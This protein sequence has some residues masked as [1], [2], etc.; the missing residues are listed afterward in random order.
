MSTDNST[1]GQEKRREGKTSR[2]RWGAG[3]RRKIQTDRRRQM[4][5]GREPYR[6]NKVG[7]TEY[8]T[9]VRRLKQKEED[10]YLWMSVGVLAIEPSHLKPIA[11]GNV[12]LPN[13][14]HGCGSDSNFPVHKNQLE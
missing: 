6:Q 12:D 7:E 2:W 9:E 11:S 14:D 1:E 5:H 13:T 4:R 3:G 10:W 8:K